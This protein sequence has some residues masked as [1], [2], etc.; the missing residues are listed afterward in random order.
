MDL[1]RGQ[2]VQVF[3]GAGWAKAS[4]IRRLGPAFLVEIPGRGAVAVYDPRNV[5]PA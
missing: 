3:M 4:F 5:R 1:R 2:S